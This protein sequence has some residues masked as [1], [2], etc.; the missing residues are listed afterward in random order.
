MRRVNLSVVLL[1]YFGTSETVRG[2]LEETAVKPDSPVVRYSPE[3]L[4]QYMK[5][6]E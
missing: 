6:F 5:G 3:T 2:S 4:S 1:F